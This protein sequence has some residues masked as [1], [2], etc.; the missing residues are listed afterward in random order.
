MESIFKDDELIDYL[1]KNPLHEKNEKPKYSLSQ[2]V[3]RSSPY[4]KKQ[5]ECFLSS[6]PNDNSIKYPYSISISR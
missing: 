5:E 4:N 2:D 3:H 1:A 6:T